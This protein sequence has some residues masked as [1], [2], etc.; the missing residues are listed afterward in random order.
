MKNW[1]KTALTI[2]SYATVAAL[3][4]GGTVA[5][6]TDSSSDSNGM[7]YGNVKIEQHE[8]QRELNDDGTY[9][10]DTIDSVTS[11]VLEDFEQGKLMLPT[12][13]PTNYGAGSWDET[14]VRMTQVDSYGSMQ[15]FSNANAID[16]FVTVENTGKN[17]AFIRTIVAIEVGE[18]DPELVGSSYHGTWSKNEI[19][20]VEI[21][22]V[23]YYL[24]EYVY[25]GGQLS[26]GSWRHENGILP[27]G[28]TSYPS[29]SQVY[30]QSKATNEDLEA[31]DG[32]KN[33][34]IDILVVSQAAQTDKNFTA[35]E[36]LDTAFGEV[37]AEN[38]AKWFGEMESVNATPAS[39]AVRPAGYVPA[40]SDVVISGLTV[41]D[42]SD[43][44]T[45]LRALTNVD[46]AVVNGDLTVTDSYLDGTYA[47][48]VYGDNTGVL[49]VEDSTLKGWIS[50]SGFTSA[51]FTNCSFG[52]NS[53]NQYKTLCVYSDTVV[54]D[55]DFEAGYE[56]E[57]DRNP[58]ATIT[59]VNCTIGGEAL[60]S[61][62]QFTIASTGA[63]VVVD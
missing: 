23:N 40:G 19:G 36:M 8:Y 4:I 44:A 45:N 6:L 52:I 24:I 41:I 16:K 51:S 28:D 49:T 11:Y 47:M 35:K 5:Y 20:T 17:D 38:A 63:T 9:K 43:D 13:D 39:G 54:T 33:G 53:Q 1:K 15:V 31:L 37:N 42:N 56:L 22:G 12:T 62:D 29:L 46:D 61:A 10:T 34:L 30:L 57:L 3:A 58:D 2:S 48:N 55:C 27:A 59:F 7:T 14:G 26:D 60:T 32:N 18:A 50:W 25:M 21:D